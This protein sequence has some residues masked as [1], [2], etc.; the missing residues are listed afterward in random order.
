M[1]TDR[2]AAGRGYS[3]PGRAHAL[4]VR[5]VSGVFGLFTRAEHLSAKRARSAL[6]PDF[7]VR[8]D[9]VNTCPAASSESRHN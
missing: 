1:I 2:A 4:S 5:R 3:I 7:G 9:T 6:G 8:R